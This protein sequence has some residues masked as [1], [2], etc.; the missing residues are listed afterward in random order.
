M[1]EAIVYIIS[2]FLD[3]KAMRSDERDALDLYISKHFN[4]P[5]AHRQLMSM[6]K[7]TF[8]SSEPGAAKSVGL[9]LKVC[10]LLCGVLHHL[11]SL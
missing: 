3:D 2:V 8:S 6:L 7:R 9:S 5:N 1:Y 11:T 10:I 4:A